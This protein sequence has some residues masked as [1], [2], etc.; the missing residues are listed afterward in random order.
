[1]IRSLRALHALSRWEGDGFS[2]YPL[3]EDPSHRDPR[4]PLVL[5]TGHTG[6]LYGD[7]QLRTSVPAR[8]V[9]DFASGVAFRLVRVR[10]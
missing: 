4:P 10:A 2:S 8:E 6:Y 3:T 9:L 1:M 5:G 7:L